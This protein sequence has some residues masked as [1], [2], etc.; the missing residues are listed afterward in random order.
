[1][2]KYTLRT[3]LLGIF[4]LVSSAPAQV[5]AAVTADG[6]IMKM[7]YAN[8]AVFFSFQEKSGTVWDCETGAAPEALKKIGWT[9]ES[10]GKGQQISVVYS[11]DGSHISIMKLTTYRLG[12]PYATLAEQGKTKI[13]I[14]CIN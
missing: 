1:M 12:K 7:E 14:V 10:L 6:K 4:L 11:R 2:M 8:P 13:R 9:K 3:A 5:P